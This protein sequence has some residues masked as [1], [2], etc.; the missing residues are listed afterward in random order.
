VR[1]KAALL[2]GLGCFAALAHADVA[3]ER[4]ADLHSNANIDQFLVTHIELILDVQMAFRQLQGS[5]VLEYKRLDPRATELVLDTRDLNIRDV[6]QLSTDFV[7]ATESTKPFWVNRPYRVGKANANLGSAL[8][9]DLP[10]STQPVQAIKIE[11]ETSPTAAGLRWRVPPKG[12]HK[13]DPFMWSQSA[14]LGARSWIPLQDTPQVRATFRAHIEADDGLL[15]VMGVRNDPKVK[16]NGV[17][18]FT[19]QQAIPS[20]LIAL[21]AGM[22]E[23][24]PVGT[25]TGVYS[26][27]A[28]V[29]AA[30]KEF[31]DAEAM[32]AAAEKILGKYPFERF[33]VLVMPANFPAAVEANPGLAFVS[34]T[35]IAGDK[36]LVSTLAN[37]VAHSWSGNLVTNA[38]WRDRWLNEAFAAYLQGRIMTAVYGE[39]REKLEEVLDLR[40]LREAMRGG[41]EQDQ[42]LAADLSSPQERPATREIMYE[43]GRLFLNYLDA[44]F[45]R[46]RFDEFLRG[47]FEHFAWQSVSTGQFLEYLQQNL[48]NRFPGIVTAAAASDWVLD[49]GLPADAVLPESAD[50]AAIDTARE[51]WINGSLSASQLGARA[52]LGTQWRY[53][54]ALLPQGLPATQL[55]ELDKAYSL[56]VTPDAEIAR[57]WLEVAIADN[58]RP[59]FA[60]IEEY[61]RTVGRYELIAPLYVELMKTSAGTDLA[62]KAFGLAHGGYDTQVAKDIEAIVGPVPVSVEP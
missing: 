2:F 8:Y 4:E 5:V 33:D 58:Y 62:K 24:K 57:S 28:G 14:P 37:G 3:G 46:E 9:I 7:G 12:S 47:Y 44:K 35:V 34:P 21:A 25:R 26:E 41:Q 61:L 38:T 54:L 22:L 29:K 59:A 42:I 10:A 13:I 55:A 16:R 60:R 30:V 1:A 11:Y 51:A 27:K 52:W 48:L 43:K 31:A 18:V 15:A 50:T 40:V 32:L 23:F 36:S 45:G 39:P 17:Y 49:P 19:S 6:S 56:T 20:S 53:F